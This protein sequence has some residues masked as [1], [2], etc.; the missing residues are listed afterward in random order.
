M[1]DRT[2]RSERSAYETALVVLGSR[3]HSREELRRK[4]FRKGFERSEV[5]SALERLS[6]SRLVDDAQFAGDFARSKLTSQRPAS[7]RR[8]RQ[9]LIRRGVDAHVAS[10]AL[11]LI[12]AE[13]GIDET[14]G[15]EVAARKKLL[16]MGSLDPAV[17]RRR[18]F[19][20]LAR[21]GYDLDDINRLLRRTFE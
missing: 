4:L 1:A 17:K 19:S 5:E 3:G 21:K 16:S 15:L 20:Y 9:E 14:T 10:E 2:G 12:V 11:D 7:V 6:E 8:V 13:E 18:L